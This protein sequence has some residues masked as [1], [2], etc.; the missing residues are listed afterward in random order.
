MNFLFFCFWLLIEFIDAGIRFYDRILK[1]NI[2]LRGLTGDN[3]IYTAKGNENYFLRQKSM[4]LTIRKSY[5]EMRMEE[6]QKQLNNPNVT[7]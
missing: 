7:S 5:F 1:K 4:P 6:L 3:S 2:A